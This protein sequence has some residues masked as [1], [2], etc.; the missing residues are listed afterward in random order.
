M[1]VEI[2]RWNASLNASE[3]SV[4]HSVDYSTKCQ[5]NVACTLE[6]SQLTINLSL[7]VHQRTVN[8]KVRK[9]VAEPHLLLADAVVYAESSE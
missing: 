2:L 7:E 5:L 8:Y 3:S 6:D 9:Y 1:C 4:K